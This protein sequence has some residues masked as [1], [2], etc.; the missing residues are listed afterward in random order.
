MQSPHGDEDDGR[1]QSHK[2]LTDSVWRKTYSFTV[3]IFPGSPFKFDDL[4]MF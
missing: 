1:C 3:C 4:I 2:C